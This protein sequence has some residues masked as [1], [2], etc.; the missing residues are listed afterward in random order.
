MKV[1]GLCSYPLEAAC[2]RYRLMQF[3]EPLAEKGISLTVS[4]LLDKNEF[5]ALYRRGQNLRKAAQLINSARKRLF[6][7]FEAREFDAIIVQREAMIIGPPVF[8]WLYKKIGKCPIILD[9]DDATYLSYVS[10]TYGR[11]GSALKFFGK[12]DTLIGWSETVICG[13]RHIAEY[14]E[15][16]GTNAV[17][18]PTVVDTDKFY[19]VQKETRKTPVVGWIGTHSTFPFLKSLFPVFTNLAR[20]YDFILKIVGAGG[21]KIKLDGVAV[22][23][24]DWKLE[25]ETSDFQSLDIGLYPLEATETVSKEWLAGK[26]GFKAI[27]YMSVGIP[28]V[29]TP[30]GICGEIGVENE[31]H[32]SALT[33]EQWYGSLVKL[34]ESAELRNDMGKNGRSYALKHY[35]VSQQTEKIADV[36]QKAVAYSKK[37]AESSARYT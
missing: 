32:F 29:V 8:E 16:K 22:E 27:Q 15:G 11:L 4:P 33:K 7:S 36:I 12:T 2:T 31:T 6:D 28:F 34:L 5:A 17:I 37:Q 19:P 14:V 24:L 23:N 21:D 25:R 1:L 9:L 3:I 13:N 10:P 20:K 35:N 30:V 18:V 26:S